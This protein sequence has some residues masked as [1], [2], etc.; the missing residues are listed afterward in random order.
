VASSADPRSE[1]ADRGWA[2]ALFGAALAL[3]AVHLVTIRDSPFFSNLYIDPL[4][5]DEWARHIA[6]G[7]WMG[8]RPFFLDPL[9][10]YFLAAIYSAAGPSYL[11][12]AAVQSLL[13]ALVA[14]LVLL[15]ARP[16]FGSAVARAAGAVA[17]CYLPAVF[18]GGV[19]MKP[20][21]STFLS[22]LALWLLSRGLA[23]A[24]RAWW[25]L[26]G[27]TT[28]LACL[29]RGNLVLL[30]L[31]LAAWILARADAADV[32][33]GLGGLAGRVR[34]PARRRECGGFLLGAAVVLAL[35]AAHNYAASGEFVLTTANAG[36][37]FFIGNNPANRSGEYQQLPFIRP[38]PKYE[39][40]DFDREAERRAG[41]PLTDRETS[42]FWFG[43]SWRWIRAHP[44]DWLAVVGRKLR[45]L[46]GAFE[47]PDSLDYYLYRETAPVLRLPLPGFG[48]LGPLALLG[49]AL[50]LPRRGWPRLLVHFVAA[51]SITIVAFFV[52]SRFRMVITPALHVLAAFAAL[53]LARRWSA[54]RAG[55]RDRLAAAVGPTALLLVFFLFVNVPVR[56]RTDTWSYRVADALRLPAVPETSALGHFNLGVVYAARAKEAGHEGES[57]RL[58]ALAEAELRRSLALAGE[59]RQARKYVELGKVLARQQRTAEAI[60]VYGQ[61][62]EIE[63]GNWRTHHALGLLYRRQGEEAAAVAAFRRALEIAPGQA[64]SAAALA[65]GDK[66]SEPA[67]SPE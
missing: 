20:A 63:P 56:A 34:R 35:P 28:A 22:A 31:P 24:G 65:E 57:Q 33:R 5:Y 6:A 52:F 40:Q 12:V 53:E 8:E 50:A 37:N 46:W 62:A 1:R 3:R 23:G 25:P 26:A 32:E 47:T 42:A 44:A 29:T 43:E 54:A 60:E 51:Y 39:Q 59:P 4:W 18:S 16:W 2:L 41:R 21:L 45:S 11:A 13:G 67:P 64:A 55:G 19:L 48:L 61:A 30:L 15:A 14:P 66:E 10:A 38:N 49:L 17:A 7:H 27:V 9:Y 58:L 36:A